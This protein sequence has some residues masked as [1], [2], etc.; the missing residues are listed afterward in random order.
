VYAAP[1]LPVQDTPNAPASPRPAS[2]QPT[3]TSWLSVMSSLERARARAYA[4]GH[5]AVL[6][7]VYAD[8]SRVGAADRRLLSRMA[9]R[10]ERAAGL[11]AF[12]QAARVLRMSG[13]RLTLRV[14]D[15]LTSYDVI[16]PHGQ[17]VRHG[18]GRPAREW[19]VVLVRTRAGWRIWSISGQEPAAS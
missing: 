15:A 7:D 3:A 16:G 2:Q 12:V 18:L 11:R 14:A 9:A 10:G 13:G 19:R 5:V 4:L 6:D 1:P 17:V 8:G